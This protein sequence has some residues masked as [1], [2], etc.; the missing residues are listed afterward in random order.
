MRG[1]T[2]SRSNCQSVQVVDVPPPR[3]Q[4]YLMFEISTRS[5]IGRDGPRPVCELSHPAP[6][7]DTISWPPAAYP[8]PLRLS[9]S[10]EAPAPRALLVDTAQ[11]ACQL[12]SM[13]AVFADRSV[14]IV[15]LCHPCHRQ[16]PLPRLE[17]CPQWVCPRRMCCLCIGSA[18]S[19]SFAGPFVVRG[20]FYQNEVEA[21]ACS[22]DVQ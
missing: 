6:A 5:K 12:V 11:Y 17:V 20:E 14:C 19:P 13:C 7:L 8:R 21:T 18:V 1:A 10:Q 9:K 16:Q 3:R 2:E 15:I 4:S 22:I